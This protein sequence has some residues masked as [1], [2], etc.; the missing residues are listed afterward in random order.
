[1]RYDSPEFGGFVA[2]ASWGEDDLWDT[3][4][5]YKG[6]IHD[7]KLIGKIGYGESTDP[8][9]TNCGGPT[10]N[11]KCTWWG[12]AATAMHQPTGL[13][14]YGGYG[15][16][17]IDSLPAGLDDTS[18]TYFLQ[19]GIE[20]KWHALGKTTIFGEYRKDEAGASTGSNASAAASARSTPAAPISTFYAGGVVQNIEAAAMDLYVIYRHAEGDYTS[21]ANAK[22]DIDDFDMVISGARIQF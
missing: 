17:T 16:Q 22:V 18:T 5:T 11:F 12:A 9:A 20:R 1:M 4:L 13:Y 6:E 7:F 8:V 21:S 2:S 10:G 19:P 15:Q 14:L 3:S